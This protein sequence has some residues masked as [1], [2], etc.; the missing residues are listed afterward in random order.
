M[1]ES[2][3]VVRSGLE[4]QQTQMD[5]ISNNLANINTPGFKR[6][7]AIFQDLLYQNAAQVGGFTSQATNF[8]SGLQR[9]TGS[10]SSPPSRS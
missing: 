1:I 3:S 9:G 2:L 4:G 6:A 10:T 8:P 5:L 7:R